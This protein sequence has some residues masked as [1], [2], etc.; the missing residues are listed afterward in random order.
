MYNRNHVF[1]DRSAERLSW[2]I[3]VSWDGGRKRERPI[4]ADTQPKSMKVDGYLALNLIHLVN[5]MC[6]RNIHDRAITSNIGGIISSTIGHTVCC[7]VVCI[8]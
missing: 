3:I 5:R 7:A 2:V 1:V 4:K 8:A 6:C